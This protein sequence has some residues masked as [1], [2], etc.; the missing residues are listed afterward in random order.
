MSDTKLKRANELLKRL[1]DHSKRCTY[2]SRAWLP[3]TGLRTIKAKLLS[4]RVDI[5]EQTD[6]YFCSC[7]NYGGERA[8]ARRLPLRADIDA[9]P[10]NEETRL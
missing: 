5:T 1:G 3:R 4:S 7:E 2:A 6:T 8:K 9:L 10:T